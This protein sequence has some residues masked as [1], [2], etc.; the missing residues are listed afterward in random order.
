LSTLSSWGFTVFNPI[1]QR[2]IN[3]SKIL[4]MALSSHSSRGATI[5][6]V[7]LSLWIKRPSFY[8]RLNKK[9]MISTEFPFFQFAKHL[10]YMSF[11]A[12]S[13]AGVRTIVPPCGSGM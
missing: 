5:E 9:S 11:S 1:F 3:N 13:T 6:S 12:T 4:L 7:N 8:Q 10:R 2:L